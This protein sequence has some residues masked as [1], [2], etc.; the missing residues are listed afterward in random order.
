[1]PKEYIDMTPT[2]SAVLPVYLTAYC[3][4]T[5]KGRAAAEAELKRMAELADKYIA[6]QKE[7]K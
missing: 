3:E 6:L 5:Y 4:G 7:Q 1:M 2:W